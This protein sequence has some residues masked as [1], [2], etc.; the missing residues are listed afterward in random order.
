MRPSKRRISGWGW[1]SAFLADLFDEP[2]ELINAG[3]EL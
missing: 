3:R 1:E 2:G